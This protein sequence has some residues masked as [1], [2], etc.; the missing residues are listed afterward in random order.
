MAGQL[1]DTTADML[2]A[3]SE[4]KKVEQKVVKTV[5]MLVDLMVVR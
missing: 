4:S 1:V 2:V 3:W 5:H